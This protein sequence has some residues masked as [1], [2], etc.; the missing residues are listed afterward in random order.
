MANRE[1]HNYLPESSCGEGFQSEHIVVYDPPTNVFFRLHYM[2][3][4]NQPNSPVTPQLRRRVDQSLYPLPQANCS[5][6]INNS[7]FQGCQTTLLALVAR[8]RL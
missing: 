8:R 6:L 2:I 3:M 5:T 1:P 4:S 7:A